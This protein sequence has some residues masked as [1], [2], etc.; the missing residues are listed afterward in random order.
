MFYNEHCLW[1]TRLKSQN[2]LIWI[3]D[4]LT[5][6]DSLL[7]QVSGHFLGVSASCIL[8]RKKPQFLLPCCCF[9]THWKKEFECTELSA[10]YCPAVSFSSPFC[11]LIL[12]CGKTPE[13]LLTRGLWSLVSPIQQL[14]WPQRKDD[15]THCTQTISHSDVLKY[16]HFILLQYSLKYFGWTVGKFTASLT[17][18]LCCS[19]TPMS[20]DLSFYKYSTT[21]NDRHDDQ[22]NRTKK[23]HNNNQVVMNQIS[24]KFEVQHF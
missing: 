20:P 22:T 10:V 4:H 13:G 7:K 1:E 14:H 24:H 19:D 17:V 5:L 3:Y 12:F 11:L 8:P 18:W 6:K 16:A 23:K 2:I 15:M 9:W 21:T